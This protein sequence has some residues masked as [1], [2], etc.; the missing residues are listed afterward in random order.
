MTIQEYNDLQKKVTH[1]F[2]FITPD[3]A[4]HYLSFNI[5]NDRPMNKNQVNTYVN[6]MKNGRWD[7]TGESIVFNEDGS[8]KS[9][10]HRLQAI[11][12]SNVSQGFIVVRGV[13]KESACDIGFKRTIKQIATIKGFDA[14]DTVASSAA[15][16]ILNGFSATL[17]SQNEI[18]EYYAKNETNLKKASYYARLGKNH[19]ILRKAPAVAAI[20][21][22]I[23]LFN[24]SEDTM[25]AF[26]QMVNTNLSVSGNYP[27]N[28]AHCVRNTLEEGAKKG[29]ALVN[30]GEFEVIYQGLNYFNNG[31]E[32]KRN[33]KPD[34][35]SD[36]IIEKVRALTNYKEGENIE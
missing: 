10:Q 19:S 21:A 2:E 17:K 9:G 3:V 26:C 8:L 14:F 16:I 5:N 32:R 4:K 25:S 15:S 33:L 28:T 11:V 35:K 6:D 18:L 30:R 7:F 23:I 20:Y 24:V 34:G 1:S 22:N 13:P 27:A 36:E 29:S 12:N 31:I